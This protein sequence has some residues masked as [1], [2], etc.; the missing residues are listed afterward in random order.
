MK[1]SFVIPT[2][3]EESNI[4]E[5]YNRISSLQI[6]KEYDLEYIII[7]DGSTDNTLENVKHLRSNDNKVNYISF[8]R[9]F[10]HQCALKA[11][12]DHT[13]GDI[14]IMMD[15]DLQHP[16]EL[17]NEMLA[18][19]NEGYN[20]ITTKRIDKVR[21]PVLKKITS[22]LFYKLLNWISDIKFDPGSA[23]YRLID[24]KVAAIIKKSNEAEIFFRGYISWVGFRQYQ[25][26]YNANARFSGESKY[27]LKKMMNFA[28]N[29]ITSFSLKPLRIAV[30]LG[31]IFSFSAF[32]YAIYALYMVTFTDRT[33][34][35]WAS[36]IISV[37]FLGGIQLIVLGI[38]GEYLG[39]LFLQVKGRPSYIIAETSL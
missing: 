39:K 32:L 37:L 22:K 7:D 6:L 28:V 8:S 24:K 26:Q 10:G 29:G 12:I 17:I 13:D 35:G 9:N 21:L 4:I 11:G 31:L 1:V 33:I 3:N 19:W 30:V 38:F 36:V 5:L 18:K 15:A 14:I 2:Y 23:D 27:S 20:V 34:Q 16:P 25:I